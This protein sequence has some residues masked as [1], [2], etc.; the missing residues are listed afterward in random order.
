MSRCHA[1]HPCL[2][3][4]LSHARRSKDY[5]TLKHEMAARAFESYIIAKLQANNGA[6]DYLANIVSKA[7]WDAAEAI[8]RG[9]FLRDAAQPP[10]ESYPYP[11]ESEQPGIH[12]AFDQFFATLKTEPTG[13]GKVRLYSRNDSA[14]YAR[15]VDAV[16]A[17]QPFSKQPL[18]LGETPAVYR[19]LG[20][21][22]L[23]LAIHPNDI[24]KAFT[25]H[26]LTAKVLK[27]VPAALQDPL[28]VFASKTE[29]GSLVALTELHSEDG[30][31]IVAAIHL[32]KRS[33]FVQVNELASIH[34]KDSMRSIQHWLDS[35]LLRYLNKE[36]SPGWLRSHSLYLRQENTNQGSTVKIL[37]EK[38]I[39]KQF[40]Q[41]A[42]SAA[43]TLSELTA[44]FRDA[45]GSRADKMLA[46]GS[47]VIVQSESEAPQGAEPVLNMTA[48]HG[49]P[50]T[51][52]KFSLAHIGTGEGAQAYGWGLY[53]AGKREVADFYRQNITTS[54]YLHENKFNVD[55][56]SNRVVDAIVGAVERLGDPTAYVEW[57][58]G[59]P[60]GGIRQW[61][62]QPWL[63][64][65]W[66]TA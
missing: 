31:P 26:G 48:W 9:D 64:C 35:G 3:L 2:V 61:P 46:N 8:Q 16:V 49:S 17:G 20:A 40:S 62:P 25:K 32:D 41:T 60:Y 6:N 28:M 37:S 12:A 30:K 55:G 59:Y 29:P 22:D 51:F 36:K 21:P 4:R 65:I 45:F 52:D 42:D 34:G 50:H 5:W 24:H 66:M 23:P 11:L 1:V 15:T 56:S 13:D 43:S 63:P 53:F 7:Y 57:G 10:V 47:V 58:A 54:K 44:A 33:G 19:A 18:H 38:D 27:Q 14:R 39:G